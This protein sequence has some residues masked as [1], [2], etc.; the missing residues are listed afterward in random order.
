MVEPIPYKAGEPV[1]LC[2]H[3]D[4]AVQHLTQDSLPTCS[5]TSYTRR[6]VYLVDAN[7]ATERTSQVAKAVNHLERIADVLDAAPFH[8]WDHPMPE[9]AH[10]CPADNMIGFEKPFTTTEGVQSTLRGI[11]DRMKSGRL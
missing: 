7:A 2:I 4:D 10:L 5:S 1:W 6:R 11:A 9:G 3:N 8:V